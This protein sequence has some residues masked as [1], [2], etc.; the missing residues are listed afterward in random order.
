MAVALQGSSSVCTGQV[1]KEEFRQAAGGEDKDSRSSQYQFGVT[2]LQQ[3]ISI[4]TLEKL[5]L[6]L[7][8]E[9]VLT[10]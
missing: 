6:A 2:R 1:M 4:Q 7:F 8:A 9:M 5:S 10:R 3:M